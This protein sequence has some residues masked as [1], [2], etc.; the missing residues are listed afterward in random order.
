MKN[1]QKNTKVEN[2]AVELPTETLPATE[3]N[4]IAKDTGTEVMAID[5]NMFLTKDQLD[6]L[7]QNDETIDEDL[8]AIYLKG[9]DMKPNEEFKAVIVGWKTIPGQNGKEIPAV[10]LY[11]LRDG[12]KQMYLTAAAMITSECK[13]LP[14]N[15]TV[16]ITY[17]GTKPAKIG[18][19]HQ[20]DVKRVHHLQK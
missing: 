11:A 4:G 18:S 20:F 12:Q 8:T 6:W 15:S 1:E 7:L 10:R 14:V 13:N 2:E 19:I 9:T 17:K 3:K 16:K 5:E